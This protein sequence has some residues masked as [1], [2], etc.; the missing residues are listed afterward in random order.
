MAGDQRGRLL[1]RPRPSVGYP[2]QVVDRETLTAA[3]ADLAAAQAEQRQVVLAA[4]PK[5]SAARRLADK[6]L[7]AAQAAADACYEVITLTALPTS[8]EITAETLAAAH[9]PTDEQMA[10]ARKN[11][12]EAA[13]R[14]EPLPP[15]P[16]WNE[17][18]FRPALLAACSDNGMSEEDW[19]VFLAE[20][21]SA[22]EVRGLWLACLAVNERERV[23]DPLVIPKG[24]TAMLSSLLS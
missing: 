24:S 19:R 2:V 22:G 3:Q 9:P 4:K 13:R 15:W 8:G 18:T 1:S 11:R 12:D 16:S 21:M 17:D 23:A 5:T 6:R 14:G 7:A 10:A 20:R